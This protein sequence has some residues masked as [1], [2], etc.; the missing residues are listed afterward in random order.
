MYAELSLTSQLHSEDLISKIPKYRGFVS[1]IPPLEQ[2]SDCEYEY[3]LIC[4]R[5]YVSSA[6]LKV[7]CEQ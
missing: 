3:E 6:F 4:N 5:I 1:D 7:L 2:G